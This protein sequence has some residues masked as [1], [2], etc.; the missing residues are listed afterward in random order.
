MGLADTVV[1]SRNDVRELLAHDDQLLRKL[2]LGVLK[3]HDS[4]LA[5]KSMAVFELSEMYCTSHSKEDFDNLENYL[6]D[7]KPNE[8][9]MVRAPCCC[10]IRVCCGY[11]V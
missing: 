10:Q 2:F 9:I 8:A 1:S 11:T 6:E 5:S 3:H 4:E 7:L